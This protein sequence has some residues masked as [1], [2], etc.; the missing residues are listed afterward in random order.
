[1]YVVIRE[2]N[3]WF[4]PIS[5]IYEMQMN[6]LGKPKLIKDLLPDS[7]M[8]LCYDR[9]SKTLFVNNPKSGFIWMYSA[10]GLHSNFYK[11]F[12][13][14]FTNF[15]GLYYYINRLNLII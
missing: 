15:N 7:E 13:S 2:S 1:M 6:G 4:Y 10:K 8:L 9:D 3:T 11:R 12:K 14:C 5:T